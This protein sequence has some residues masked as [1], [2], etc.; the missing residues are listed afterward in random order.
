MPNSNYVKGRRYEY[1]TMQKLRDMGCDI[2]IRSAGSHSPID[3]IGIDSKTRHIFFLQCKPKS[4]SNNK[5]ELIKMP[6]EW[7]NG[8]FTSSFEVV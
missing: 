3:V 7:L 2:V 8:S 6:L 5:K 1:K 4:M